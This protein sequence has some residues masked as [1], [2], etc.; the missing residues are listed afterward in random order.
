MHSEEEGSPSWAA[1]KHTYIHPIHFSAF[2]M[3]VCAHT[4][5]HTSDALR[6]RSRQ[7]KL[8]SDHDDKA[9]SKLS[10]KTAGRCDTRHLGAHSSTHLITCMYVFVFVSACMHAYTY[11]HTHIIVHK[12]PYVARPITNPRAP[13]TMIQISGWTLLAASTTLFPGF[14]VTYRIYIYI[15]IYIQNVP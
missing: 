3:Y 2:G 12:L 10:C 13:M 14:N 8:G 7:S 1:I 5:I 9:C 6:R 15:Y 11:T 4:Y